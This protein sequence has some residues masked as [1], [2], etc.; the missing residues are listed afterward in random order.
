MSWNFEDSSEL[1]L[2]LAFGSVST[3]DWAEGCRQDIM[4]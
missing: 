3:V 4:C 2:H 1:V